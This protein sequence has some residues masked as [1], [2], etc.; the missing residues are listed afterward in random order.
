VQ[1]SPADP[2]LA[3]DLR[4]D[5][6]SMERTQTADTVVFALSEE[7]EISIALGPRHT[8]PGRRSIAGLEFVRD[9][10]SAPTHACVPAGQPLT[11][12]LGDLAD[13][14][15]ENFYW[16]HP[17]NRTFD[18]RGLRA[19][20]AKPGKVARIELSVDNNDV[21]E[22]RLLR[23]GRLLWQGQTSRAPN[24]GG[25]ALRR[26]ELPA[27]IATAA[28]DE[29]LIVPVEGDGNFSIGHVTLG[30]PN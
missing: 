1:V 26:L 29:L 20:L 2:G 13:A 4:C 27:A 24:N 8:A 3:L 22:V 19:R 23:N 15:P 18:S 5:G 7:R 12:D 30:N 16:A 28:G 14:K 25:L 6:R 11:I 21:Y 17:E 10:T 9:E